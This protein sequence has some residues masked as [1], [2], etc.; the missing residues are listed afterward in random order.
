[1][2]ER[3]GEW[4]A[5]WVG[6]V[7]ERELVCVCVT[8]REW[9]R[10]RGVASRAVEEKRAKE[11]ARYEKEWRSDGVEEISALS[12]EFYYFLGQ[13]SRVCFQL[14]VLVARV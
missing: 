9:G 7:C 3:Q 12:E 1:M 8:E 11:L 6:Y 4:E 5:G 2:G 13:Q 10:C 14:C